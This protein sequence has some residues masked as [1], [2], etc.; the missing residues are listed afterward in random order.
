MNATVLQ[1]NPPKVEM[2]ADS[3]PARVALPWQCIAV[4][5]GGL[6]LTVGILWDISWH[7]TIGRDAF[8]T[9]AHMIIYL[10]GTLGGVACGYLVLKT[11]WRGTAAERAVSVRIWGMRAPLGAWI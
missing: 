7:A 1:E 10:G 11:T 2:A 9:P 6:C 3:G 5:F 4:V 8:W